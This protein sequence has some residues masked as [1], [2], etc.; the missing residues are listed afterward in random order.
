M[1][2]NNL[3]FLMISSS[4]F[5]I[6]LF[7]E[8]K[9]RVRE[10]RAVRSISTSQCMR[11]QTKTKMRKSLS[12]SR[13]M[14]TQRMSVCLNPL[15]VKALAR[16]PVRE[17][18]KALVREPAR[19]LARMKECPSSKCIRTSSAWAMT[20]TALNLSDVKTRLKVKNNYYFLRQVI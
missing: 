20:R 19:A 17:R 10:E 12:P 7:L 13:M 14:P 15:L 11:N 6:N 1:T 8:P 3:N 18:A 4:W 2:N 9:F 5:L 16:A